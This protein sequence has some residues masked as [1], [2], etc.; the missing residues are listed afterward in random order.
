M[1]SVAE[2]QIENKRVLVRCDFDVPLDEAGINDDFRILKTLPTI[3]FLLEKNSN[4]ILLAH[5]G[6]PKGQDPKLSLEPIAK[7]LT[8]LLGK[9]VVL[10]KDYAQ[11]KNAPGIVLLENLRFHEGEMSNDPTFSR[12]L[13]SL[14]EVYV[15]EAFAESH[16]QSASISGIPKLLPSYAG[17]NL[18]KEVKVL[19]EALYSPTHP[20]V[21]IIGGAKIETKL[22]LIK[23]LVK[24]ADSVL[25]GGKLIEEKVPEYETVI[26]PEDVVVAKVV[27]E[28]IVGEPLIERRTW[29]K[30]VADFKIFDI[31]Q[32]AIKEY[33]DIIHQAKMVIWNGPMGIFEDPRFELGTEMVGRAISESKAFSIVGGG[34]TVLA[35]KSFG[36]L[37]KFSHV[38]TGGGAMLHFLAGEKLPGIEALK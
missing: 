14:G 6:R 29:A 31:G 21:V 16:R 26:L 4:L 7:R 2:T 22:P 28:E 3:Q 27:D 5:L 13:A 33:T 1:I 35:L 17:F 38:S 18:L 34:D 10:E 11:A 12:E 9:E 15:N 23:N 19:S 24:I 32:E 37:D 30:S 36:L 20:Y 8:A 25:V